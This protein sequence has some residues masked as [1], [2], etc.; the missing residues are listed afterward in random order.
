MLSLESARWS[1]LEHAYGRASD[2]PPLLR[3]LQDLPGSVGQSEPWFSTLECSGPSGRCLFSFVRSGPACHRRSGIGTGK[4]RCV[5]FHFPARVEI[6]RA[7]KE[8]PIPPDLADGYFAALQRLPALVA[9]AASGRTD[10]DFAA[11]A[12]AAIAA[13]LG[14]HAMAEVILEMS[15]PGLSLEVLQ[16]LDDR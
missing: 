7:K 2:I 3:Q 16:W 6:C 8:T 15:T 14:Q 11:C 1:E 10:P 4:S 12:T 9:E 13:T 5:L